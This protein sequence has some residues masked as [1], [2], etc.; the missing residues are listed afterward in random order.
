MPTTIVNKTTKF[1]FTKRK[2]NKWVRRVAKLIWNY[3]SCLLCN[4]K[5]SHS[6][7]HDGAWWWNGFV[8]FQ[9]NYKIERKNI[10]IGIHNKIREWMIWNGLFISYSREIAKK[11]EDGIYTP[12]ENGRFWRSE[13][14]DE[15]LDNLMMMY[16]CYCCCSI[17]GRIWHFSFSIKT[18]FITWTLT[19][20]YETE[21]Q[22]CWNTIKLSPTPFSN[23]FNL[24]FFS[25][26][27]DLLLFR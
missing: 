18:F 10:F 11:K 21:F 8:L 26:E 20:L 23:F 24:F 13:T 3:A 15:K 14:M 22:L 17:L 25:C 1:V 12:N 4:K 5:W 19:W 27:W 9:M 7:N 16:G 2:W 6:P